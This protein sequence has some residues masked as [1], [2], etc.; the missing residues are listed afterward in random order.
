MNRCRSGARQLFD[1]VP[2]DRVSKNRHWVWSTLSTLVNVRPTVQHKSFESLQG[3]GWV[4]MTSFG[5]WTGGD[6]VL[7]ECKRR[8]EFNPSDVCF[9]RADLVTTSFL[10]FEGQ[11][12]TLVFHTPERHL[13]IV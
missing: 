6:L 2:D 13:S 9:F 5:N 4:A 11:M 1:T 10:P 8:V 12:T 7:P 3:S